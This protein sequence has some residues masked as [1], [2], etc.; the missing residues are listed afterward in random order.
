[1]MYF[2]SVVI[3]IVTTLMFVLFASGETDTNNIVFLKGYGWEVRTKSVEKEDIII[4]KPFDR[5]YENYNDIQLKAGLDLRP[6][7]GMKGVRYTYIVEN[8]PKDVGEEVRANVICIN[9]EPVGGDIMTVSIRG[10]IHSL[11]FDDSL[12]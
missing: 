9:N 8:Y 4:P 10:F 6:Y 7:M 2:I 5:V 12:R 1:M 11:N 3:I